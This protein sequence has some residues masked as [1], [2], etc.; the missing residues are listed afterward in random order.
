MA[1]TAVVVEGGGMKATFA[2]GALCA[3][4]EAG[5]RDFSI[6]GT[7]A[8]GAVGAWFAAGQAEYARKTWDYAADPRFLDYGRL[9]RGGPLLDHDA[10]IDIVYAKEMPLDVP[11]VRRHRHPV[12]VTASDADT[13]E[14]LVADVR[15]GDTLAWLR[16]TG[17]LPL[18]SGP[19][20]TL[21]GRRLVDGGVLEPIPLRRAVEDGHKHIL[22]LANTPPGPRRSDA[23]M[24]LH[25]AGR[26][27]PALR[28]A[29]LEHE[30]RKESALALAAAPPAGV[31]VDVV[32]SPP[33]G[34][35]RLDRRLALLHAHLERGRQAGHDY[36]KGV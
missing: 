8:G 2:H 24:V 29:I 22:L 18:F 3:F 25:L 16:A 6:Y 11:A 26:R 35:H 13:G 10:L 5:W 36:L 9:L 32:R 27:Y 28:Q 12:V 14:T 31:R 23:R 19:P 21:E 15:R 7:S 4:E 34:P 1:A 30:A 17:R 33:G 20:V